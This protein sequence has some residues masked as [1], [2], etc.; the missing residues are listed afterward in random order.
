MAEYHPGKVIRKYR[1]LKGWSQ[2]KLAEHWPKTDGE[3]GVTW[4]YVQKVEYS[5][6][7]IVDQSVLRKI[8]HL[9]DI[10]LWEFGFSE[11]DPWNPHSIPGAGKRLY[12]ETLSVH[13]G[14]GTTVT[15]NPDPHQQDY[16]QGYGDVDYFSMAKEG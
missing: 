5:K 14:L 10:P 8:S 15:A 4:H 7:N 1:E 16:H 9:L 13:L 6:R 12:S 11:Y 2:Q 3:V